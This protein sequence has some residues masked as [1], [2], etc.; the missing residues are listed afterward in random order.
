MNERTSGRMSSTTGAGASQRILV[1]VYRA[2][3]THDY[4]HAIAKTK[5]ALC[6]RWLWKIMCSFSLLDDR[7]VRGTFQ[8]AGGDGK[9][10]FRGVQDPHST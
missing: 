8:Q 7:S 1:S 2:L 4:A 6:Q 3:T 9:E 10:L 5:S